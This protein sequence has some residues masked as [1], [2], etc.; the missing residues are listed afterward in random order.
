[1]CELM[2]EK[3]RKQD[4]SISS[5]RPTWNSKKSHDAEKNF[6]EPFQTFFS[7]QNEERLLW[8]RK[9]LRK[10]SRSVENSQRWLLFGYF[11]AS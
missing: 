11:L 7:S 9:K 4:G 3:K 8:V 5:V 10:K 2:Q 6:S 1:M